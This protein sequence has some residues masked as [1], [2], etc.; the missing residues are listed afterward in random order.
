MCGQ[1]IDDG[2]P[3]SQ[4]VPWPEH[5]DRRICVANTRADERKRIEKFAVPAW[6][7]EIMHDLRAQ[8]EALPSEGN[9]LVWRKHVLD[10]LGGSNV[11]G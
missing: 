1:P 11:H 4:Y 2:A 5:A 3:A 9:G 6:R 7:E 8:V 10:L